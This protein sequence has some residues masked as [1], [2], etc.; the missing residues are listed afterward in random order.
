MF[1]GDFPFYGTVSNGVYVS[2]DGW[3]S[4][5]TTSAPPPTSTPPDIFPNTDPPNVIICP[6][7]TD[8]EPAPGSYTGGGAYYFIDAIEQKL[9]L[10]WEMYRHDGTSPE[11][12]EFEAIIYYGQDDRHITSIVFQ[13]KNIGEV[14]LGQT[15]ICIESDYGIYGLA[16]FY[17]GSP[18]GAPIPKNGSSVLFYSPAYNRIFDK[19]DVPKELSVRV[20]PNPFNATV[21]INVNNAAPGAVLE[22]F[23]IVGRALRRFDVS[24]TKTL[25]WDGAAQTGSAQPSGI[26]F[27]RL[28]SNGKTIVKRLI[29]L[30]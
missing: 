5:S 2:E 18:S 4:L 9:V 16:Y 14:Y 20:Y 11:L 26:Y 13:Y 22:I 7:W 29:M 17:K 30:K 15:A 24:G 1:G 21:A 27:A 19:P 25:L 28:T 8:L 23:D 6:L 10:E 3:A 12:I